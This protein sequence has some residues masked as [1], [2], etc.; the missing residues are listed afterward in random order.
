MA[1]LMPLIGGVNNNMVSL[2]NFKNYK[3]EK[4]SFNGKDY[5]VFFVKS[6]CGKDWHESVKLFGKD[7][8][9]IMYHA[10]E[11]QVIQCEKDATLLAV[12]EGCSVIEVSTI[13]VSQDEMIHYDEYHIIDDKIVKNTT[14]MNA[15]VRTK[16]DILADLD[17]LKQELL[18]IK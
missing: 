2:K 15:L 18:S 12:S 7:T 1:G 8:Y 5:K 6:E 13:P 3:T 16:E 11:N 14:N 4:M 9:K 17:S 10:T